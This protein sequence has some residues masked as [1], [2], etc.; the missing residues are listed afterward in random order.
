M[1]KTPFF[2]RTNYPFSSL[3]VLTEEFGKDYSASNPERMRNFYLVY[4]SRIS[5][6]A[7]QNSASRKNLAQV[8][9]PHHLCGMLGLSNHLL[10]N[11]L[12]HFTKLVTLCAVVEN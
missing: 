1:G 5:A 10:D 8:Q 12:F 3:L 6:T 2:R 9:F 7:S 11:L 4:Q